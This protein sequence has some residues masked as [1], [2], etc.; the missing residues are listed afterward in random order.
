MSQEK[1]C[2]GSEGAKAAMTREELRDAVKV[3]S[4]GDY[5]GELLTGL[6]ARLEAEI[7]RRPPATLEDGKMSVKDLW[8]E[9][10]VEGVAVWALCRFVGEDGK[11]WL[12]RTLC[13]LGRGNTYDAVHAALV[14]Y[15][16]TVWEPC[17]VAAIWLQCETVVGY[18]L[19]WLAA[20]RGYVT[21]MV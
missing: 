12:R 16:G 17:E 13:K 5:D 14:S 11:P 3:L 4:E 21:R 6:L 9:E 20:E 2:E 8:K 18:R 15:Q 10:E 7:A 19:L 1:G